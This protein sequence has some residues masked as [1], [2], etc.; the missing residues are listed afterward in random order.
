MTVSARVNQ[1]AHG[2]TPAT[3]RVCLDSVGRMLG[4]GRIFDISIKSSI[5]KLENTKF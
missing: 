4:K 5:A 2:L 3:A 1:M